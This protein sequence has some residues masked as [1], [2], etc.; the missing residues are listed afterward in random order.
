[1]LVKSKKYKLTVVIG[2]FQLKH[3]GHQLLFNKAEALGDNLLI[4]VGSASQPRTIKN[5]FT[6]EERSKMIRSH[7]IHEQDN[8]NSVFIAPVRDNVY[9]DDAWI[10]QVQ[11]WISVRMFSLGITNPD[12]VSIVGLKK[13][14]SSYYLD[15]FPQYKY[16]SIDEFKMQLD[17]TSIRN[18]LYTKPG[19]LKL[20]GN[21]IPPH[22]KAF[23]DGFQN[24]VEYQRLV[25]EFNY[26]TNYVKEWG[27]G[28]FITTDALIKKSGHICLIKRA[29]D[30]GMD[31]WALPG[32]FLEKKERIFDGCIREVDEETK[33][34]V[35][36]GLLKGSLTKT[37]VFD[38]VDRSLR[39][40]VIT[41][42]HMFDLD[43][44]DKK[45]GLPSIKAES[46]AKEARWF[47]MHEVLSMSEQ[48]FEDHL[49]M[50]K[51]MLGFE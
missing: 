22:V 37:H 28:P 38:H 40:R 45:S 21:I 19:E 33:I 10:K 34:D 15:L 42:C 31:L 13:D 5:P 48:M 17:A 46:D 7:F 41:H 1:M 12:E 18:I 44:K 50:I 35:P 47:P 25:R 8:F 9:S 32:G 3:V 36:P 6:F 4:L 24:T 2:R 23:L 16:E 43:G 26:Y 30:P 11:H 51:F 29:D 49:D 27:E 20:L 39:G 14:E